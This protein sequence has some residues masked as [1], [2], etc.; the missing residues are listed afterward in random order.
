MVGGRLWKPLKRGAGG[1]KVKNH[2][3]RPTVCNLQPSMKVRAAVHIQLKIHDIASWWWR[4]LTLSSYL[5]I[6]MFASLPNNPHQKKIQLFGVNH[7]SIGTHCRHAS[8]SQ[9]PAGS[10]VSAMPLAVVNATMSNLRHK[11]FL[12]EVCCVL[13]IQ[14]K[15]SFCLLC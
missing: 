7:R 8:L 2:C 15:Q 10:L 13:L 12:F 3:L 11:P 6:R 9:W 5:N 4:I 1:K 14:L